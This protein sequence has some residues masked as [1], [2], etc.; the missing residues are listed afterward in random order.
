[1]PH[2]LPLQLLRPL[3][4]PLERLERLGI[5]PVLALAVVRVLLPVQLER[6]PH[7]R[8]PRAIG[9]SQRLQMRLVPFVF[10]LCVDNRISLLIFFLCLGC[11]GHEQ[12]P[13]LWTVPVLDQPIVKVQVCKIEK[14]Q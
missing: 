10:F 2:L 13:K 4:L 14:G 3:L 8:E 6:R 12:G 11:I 7:R 5:R 1:V 9:Q